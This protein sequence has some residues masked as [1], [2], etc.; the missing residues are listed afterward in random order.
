[1]LDQI[2]LTEEQTENIL[3]Q[4]S[5]HC[6]QEG[7]EIEQF[8]VHI[9]EVTQIANNLDTSIYDIQEIIEKRKLEVAELDRQ[10]SSK[11]RRISRLRISVELQKKNLDQYRKTR[12]LAD[13]IRLLE[14]ELK[15]RDRIM[16]L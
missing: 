12:P 14:W 1:M 13:R 6:F 10:I 4:I 3:E 11:T 2:N 9:D 5:I 15:E 7:I 16:V 8:L